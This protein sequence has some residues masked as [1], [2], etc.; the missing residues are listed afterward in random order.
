MITLIHESRHLVVADKPSGLTTTAPSGGD[1]LTRRLQSQLGAKLHPTSRLDAEVTGLVTFARTKA[2]IAALQQARSDGRY[3]RRYL[4]LTAHAPTPASGEWRDSI[5]IDPRNRK[6]RIALTPGKPGQ[7][8][9]TACTHYAVQVPL[10]GVVALRL[11]PQTGRT[12]QLRVH[13]ARAGVPLLGD[14][15]YGGV[16]RVVL[17]DGRVVR[18]KRVMLHCLRLRLPD[19]E[20]GTLQLVSPPHDDMT[21]LWRALGGDVGGLRAR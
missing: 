19:V 11:E 9:Q 10:L 2:A 13:A 21:E 5:A 20:G 6:L 16:R 14:H 1:S 8:V 17:E 15:R 7:R 3:H 4:G 12:H 18:A